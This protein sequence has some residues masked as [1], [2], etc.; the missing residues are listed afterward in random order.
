MAVVLLFF[1]LM[2]MANLVQANKVQTACQGTM[3]Y[4]DCSRN[5]RLEIL[6]A[7]YGRTSSIICASAN[8]TTGQVNCISKFAK[9]IIERKCNKKRF[10]TILAD[11]ATMGGDPC[12]SVFK[13]VDVIYKC[14]QQK[15]TTTGIPTTVTRITSTE[16]KTLPTEKS[17]STS[18]MKPTEKQSTP[19]LTTAKIILETTKTIK[20]ASEKR[21]K[22]DKGFFHSMLVLLKLIKDKPKHSL[23]SVLIGVATGTV[24]ILATVL[25]CVCLERWHR[26]RDP[27]R[28][29]DSNDEKGEI[30]ELERNELLG[31][32]KSRNSDDHVD[33][34]FG[35]DEPDRCVSNDYEAAEDMAYLDKYLNEYNANKSLPRPPPPENCPQD[36]GAQR[37]SRRAHNDGSKG[38]SY[39]YNANNGP[40]FTTFSQ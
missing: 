3:L 40:G 13:Y 32:K 15:L 39:D 24:I 36:N 23:L 29:T 38:R 5:H 26:K 4:L 22:G 2:A 6:S 9:T 1:G 34:A 31:G 30:I 25:V 11:D 20:G 8:K 17:T 19:V 27:E 12:P 18:T 33:S 28:F 35:D 37:M 10:C 16:N 7:N 14:V 21:R